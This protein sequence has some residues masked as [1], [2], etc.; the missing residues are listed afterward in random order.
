VAL[1]DLDGIADTILNTLE[2]RLLGIVL[3]PKLNQLLVDPTVVLMVT[4]HDTFRQLVQFRLRTTG[5]K[6]L[7]NLKD[8]FKT[9]CSLA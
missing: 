8:G 6:T 4:A 5:L 9:K 3:Q 2:I 1:D 7:P